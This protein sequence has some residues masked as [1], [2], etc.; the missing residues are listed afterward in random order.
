MIRKL[1]FILLVIVLAAIGFLG[2]SIYDRLKEKQA[3]AERIAS[4]PEFSAVTLNGEMIQTPGAARGAPLILTYFNTSCEFCRA[5]IQSIQR[6]KGLRE[7]STVYLVSDESTSVLKHFA[8]DAEL[9]SLRNI[10]VL[11]DSDQQV[12]RIFGIAGVP[13]TFVYGVDGT[14][15]QSFKGETKAEV[16]Y[17][18][19]IR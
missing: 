12:K 2:Y 13:S 17:D 1:A 9:D 10:L 3:I 15:L 14:L 16:L 5:E 6:H 19:L 11:Q 4:L 18:E 8:E 7:K